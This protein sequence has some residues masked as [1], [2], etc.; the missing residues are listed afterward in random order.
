MW[1]PIYPKGQAGVQPVNIHTALDNSGGVGAINDFCR[2]N[3]NIARKV[4]GYKYHKEATWGFT[5][6][7]KCKYSV[8]KSC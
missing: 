7:I 4:V 6:C 8:A 2:V 5:T 3:W 1:A